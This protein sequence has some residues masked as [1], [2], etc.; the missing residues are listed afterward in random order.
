[1]IETR[2]ELTPIEPNNA[3]GEWEFL[4]HPWIVGS[5]TVN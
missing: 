4:G 3:K 2:L 1:M 5:V